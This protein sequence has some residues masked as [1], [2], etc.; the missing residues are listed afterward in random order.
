M[1]SCQGTNELNNVEND[2][3]FLSENLIKAYNR[4]KD[5]GKNN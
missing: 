1:D 5:K 3:N 2:L 4:A